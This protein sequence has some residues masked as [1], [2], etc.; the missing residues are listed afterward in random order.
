L[1]AARN[2]GRFYHALLC[3][4]AI[5]GRRSSLVARLDR[6]RKRGHPIR[7]PPAV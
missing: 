7:R 1:G 4:A 6:G 3:T 2:N 5:D